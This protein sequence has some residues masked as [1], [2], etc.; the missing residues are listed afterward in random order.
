V[1]AWLGVGVDDV[2]PVV[3]AQ[4]G[5]SV[6]RGVMVVSVTPGG[7]AQKAGILAGDVVTAFNGTEVENVKQLQRAVRASGIGERAEVTVVR[8]KDS[9]KFQVTLEEQPR[10]Q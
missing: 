6:K 7:P 5:L 2:T 3:A 4:E 10:S 8:G 9:Q 1:F